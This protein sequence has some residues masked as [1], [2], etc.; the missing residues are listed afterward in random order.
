M[1][2]NKMKEYAE[3]R[4]NITK[5]EIDIGDKVLLKNVT[6]QGKLVPKYQQ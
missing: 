2:K 6:Q 5:S 4:R 1:A 3:A